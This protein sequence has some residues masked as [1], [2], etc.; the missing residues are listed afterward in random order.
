MAIPAQTM[1]PQV[2]ELI[3]AIVLSTQDAET[4]LKAILPFTDSKDPSITGAMSHHEK[5]K[6]RTFGDLIERFVDA[7]RSD[8]D[9]FQQHLVRLVDHRNQ[10][11]HHF[12]EIYG[13]QLRSG[14]SQQVVDSLR[15]VLANVDAFRSALEQA[16]LH[17]FEAVRDITFVGTPEYQKFDDLCALFRRRVTR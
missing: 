7:S 4:Y 8:S 17:L 16:A 2:L 1:N 10:I 3:G 12:G 13:E 5:I 6:K 14:N 9:S 15:V 11:V